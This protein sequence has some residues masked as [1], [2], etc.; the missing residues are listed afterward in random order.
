MHIRAAIALLAASLC[1]PVLAQIALPPPIMVNT[2]PSKPAKTADSP[3]KP[4]AHSFDV[5]SFTCPIGG[6]VF[7]QEVGYSAFP[8]IT[9][10]DGSWLGDT[11]IGVQIPV[12]PDNGLVLI[13]D[14]LKSA[15]EDDDR[16]AYAE[17]SPSE[18]ERLPALIADPAYIALKEDG[19]YAQAWWLATQLGRPAEDRFFMLQRSTWATRDPAK[20]KR[21]V[22]RLAEEGP[23][24]VASLRGQGSIKS[25]YLIYV[26][27]ALREIGR[28]DDAL[29]MLDQL[30]AK[31]DPIPGQPDPDS[32]YGAGDAV[33]PMR[34]AIE[35][36]DDGRFPAELLHAKMVNDICDD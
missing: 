15:E 23:A 20:R 7:E 21:L 24:I 25:F 16:M 26:V 13:P 34:M 12:C 17:Y 4:S 1:A 32:I 19:R 18:R 10:P 11:E 28:F 22:K 27:N 30:E 2:A 6:K 3:S 9:L 8:L 5:R 36:K 35:Q 33:G 14:L 29:T 31:G